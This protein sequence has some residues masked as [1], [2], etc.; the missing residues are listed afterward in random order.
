MKPKADYLNSTQDYEN[1]LSSDEVNALIEHYQEKHQIT[2]YTNST[3]EQKGVQIKTIIHQEKIEFS[4]LNDSDGIDE[5]ILEGCL[6][7]TVEA[8]NHMLSIQAILS[9]NQWVGYMYTAQEDNGHY[10]SFLI[11]KTR[12][13]KPVEWQPEYSKSILAEK[14]LKFLQHDYAYLDINAFLNLPAAADSS[15]EDL[16]EESVAEVKRL[17]MQMDNSSCASLGLSLLKNYLKNNAEQMQNTL[18]IPFYRNNTPHYFFFP[19]PQSLVY[20]Q[21]RHF[22]QAI[23][24]L[25]TEK[26]LER[27]LQQLIAQTK[28][29]PRSVYGE[30]LLVASD[31]KDCLQ[32]LEEFSIKWLDLYAVAKLKREQVKD[33]EYNRYLAYTAYRLQ[34]KAVKKIQEKGNPG[35]T[36]LNTP[37]RTQE[38]FLM[39]LSQLKF[40]TTQEVAY[41]LS[42][43]PN[44][45]RTLI[46]LKLFKEQVEKSK[47]RSNDRRSPVV[48]AM[49]C[50]V[51]LDSQQKMNLLED[52]KQPHWFNDLVQDQTNITFL[53]R[54][55]DL[56]DLSDSEVNDKVMYFLPILKQQIQTRSSSNPNNA[57]SNSK[58]PTDIISPTQQCL[59][60]LISNSEQFLAMFTPDVMV[61]FAQNSSFHYVLALLL[62]CEKETV[63]LLL[64]KNHTDFLSAL[65]N[66]MKVERRDVSEQYEA[67]LY[68]KMSS[69][70]QEANIFDV[71]DPLLK[72]RCRRHFLTEN[73]SSKSKRLFHLLLS[74]FAVDKRQDFLES[75]F[76]EKAGKMVTIYAL[77]PLLPSTANLRREVYTHANHNNFFPSKKHA[78]EAA[79]LTNR[80]LNNQ[81]EV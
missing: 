8:V 54:W 25:L 52:L 61:F 33:E 21:S 29:M 13:I 20:S 53:W 15:E 12:I 30:P 69:K 65:F 22:N 49:H 63:L 66:A 2:I 40:E 14:I 7:I 23:E 10:E 62:A 71:D 37:I 19:S 31:A 39:E 75:T 72:E 16:A 60:F 26:G 78:S 9:D 73:F 24:S 81:L 4:F 43:I 68:E 67:D 18:L 45:L 42:K 74:T 64:N 47:T 70:I 55:F 56:L 36:L 80:R 51:L 3:L 17:Y 1:R 50:M 35:L 46:F 59:K 44:E 34:N 11:S 57:G 27:H 48:I 79:V 5:E 32:S 58:S 28:K 38:S 41:F 76:Q 77:E 6:A